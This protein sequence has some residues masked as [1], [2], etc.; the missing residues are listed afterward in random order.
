MLWQNSGVKMI[1]DIE[2]D[3]FD[4][5]KIH[6]LSFTEGDI[7]VSTTDYAEMKAALCAAGKIIGHN[8]IR[9]DLPV[10]ERLI[11]FKPRRDQQVIDT[12]ALSWYVNYDLPRS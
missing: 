10:L 11:G 4:A 12:L 8:I 7:V 6:C 3:G 1:F 9:Y 2:T 5:T